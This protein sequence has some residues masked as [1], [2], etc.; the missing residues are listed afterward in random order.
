LA[1]KLFAARD[2]MTVE[3]T[4]A[5]KKQARRKP[6]SQTLP[7]SDGLFARLEA[8]ARRRGLSNVEQLLETWQA[9]RAASLFCFVV[10]L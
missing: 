2:K 9:T 6:M 4:T 1:L 10:F 3:T 8:A 5:Q 7:L